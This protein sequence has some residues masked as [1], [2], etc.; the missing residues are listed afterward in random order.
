M[1]LEA[2]F[3]ETRTRFWGLGSTTF[4]IQ[5]K[6]GGTEPDECYCIGTEKEFPQRVDFLWNGLLARS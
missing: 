2:Y 4:R 3:Q 6:K 5:A 1:L